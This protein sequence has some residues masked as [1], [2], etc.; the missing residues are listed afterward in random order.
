MAALPFCFGGWMEQEAM[1][2]RPGDQSGPVE[3]KGGGVAAGS[4]RKKPA[5]PRPR[6][7][8]R[9][10]RARVAEALPD[11]VKEFV[12]K[13]KEG[14]VA[15]AKVL[16]CLSGLDDG[17]MPEP[18]KNRTKSYVALLLERLGPD[19]RKQENGGKVP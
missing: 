1:E 19:P 4:K 16:L 5:A 17:K 8:K 18:E 6:N 7:C 14:S 3:L 11:I 12:E 2:D 13:A 9:F 15:H 10:A